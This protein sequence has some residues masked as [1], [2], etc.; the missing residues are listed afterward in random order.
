MS[1]A[2]HIFFEIYVILETKKEPRISQALFSWNISSCSY[3][4]PWCLDLLGAPLYSHH[5]TGTIIILH[6]E[7]SLCQCRPCHFSNDSIHLEAAVPLKRPDR[8][9]CVC[10]ELSVLVQWPAVVTTIGFPV[11][12]LLEE[13]DIGT[14]GAVSDSFT[15]TGCS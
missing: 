4:N 2:Y 14:L 11:E 13:Q 10:P 9:Q 5:H 6:Y 15:G 7:D 12:D 8:S 3:F 1:I